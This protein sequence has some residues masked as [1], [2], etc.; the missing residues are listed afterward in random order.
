[1]FILIFGLAGFME[2]MFAFR[3]I[4]MLSFGHIFDINGEII[5]NGF[6]NT[7]LLLCSPDYFDYIKYLLNF[8]IYPYIYYE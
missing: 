3:D 6:E 1:M 5:M 2:Y 4:H 8:V 7:F